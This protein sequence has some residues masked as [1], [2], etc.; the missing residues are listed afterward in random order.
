MTNITATPTAEGDITVTVTYD[1]PA[2]GGPDTVTLRQEDA[3]ALAEALDAALAQADALDNEPLFTIEMDEEQPQTFETGQTVIYDGTDPLVMP[4]YSG[5]VGTIVDEWD[6]KTYNVRFGDDVQ[7]AIRSNSLTLVE[8]DDYDD[9]QAEALREALVGLPVRIEGKPTVVL[10]DER[11]DTDDPEATFVGF[12][13][14]D[15]GVIA[16]WDSWVED[17]YDR[18]SNF[19]VNVGGMVQTVSMDNVKPINIED[20][21]RITLAVGAEYAE[22]RGIVPGATVLVPPSSLLAA[23]LGEAKVESVEDGLA[24][25]TYEGFEAEEDVRDEFPAFILYAK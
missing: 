3:Q 23:L 13:D 11:A 8:D 6:E 7:Q 19:N 17:W 21:R 25:V 9:A 22:R 24:T 4:V 1:N 18:A 20:V 2:M 5:Q 15:E 16:P 14:G 10:T 12:E